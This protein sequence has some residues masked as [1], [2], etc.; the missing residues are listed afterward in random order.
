MLRHAN[1]NVTFT[2]IAKMDFLSTEK[3]LVHALAKPSAEL[4]AHLI[5]DL[6]TFATV[7][8]MNNHAREATISIRTNVNAL[9]INLN[10]VSLIVSRLGRSIKK[11]VNANVIELRNVKMVFHSTERKLVHA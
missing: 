4:G 5:T 7:F 11:T 9:L 6:K 8:A 1:V 2:L 3:K 10:I